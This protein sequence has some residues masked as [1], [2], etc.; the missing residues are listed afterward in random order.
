M[1]EA[2]LNL[3]ELKYMMAPC[4]MRNE[5]GVDS[6]SLRLECKCGTKRVIEEY[7]DVAVRALEM[8]GNSSNEEFPHEEKN[9]FFKH[10]K[11][12]FGSTALCLSGGGSI[13]MY[14]KG[15]IKALLEADRMPNI[16]SGS[17]GG[18]ITAAMVACKTNK[19]LLDDIIQDDVSTRYI[20][21]SWYPLVP[22]PARSDHTLHQDGIF[23]RVLEF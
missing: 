8:L 2:K 20:H 22:T 18:V 23:S 15:I 4:V 7:N 12:S 14:H 6:P 19:E 13:A 17:S 16:M 11:Q 1:G 3:R 5:L 21:S 10:I 9:Q